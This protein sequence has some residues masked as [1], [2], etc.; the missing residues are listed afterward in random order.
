MIIFMLYHAGGA[1]VKGA[2]MRYKMLVLVLQGNGVRPYYLLPDAG[3]AQAALRI[4]AGAAAVCQY[5]G[6][7]EYLADTRLLIRHTGTV[8]QE[9]LQGAVYLRGRQP[10]AMG[11]VQRMP[12]VSDQLC[13]ARFSRCYRAACCTQDGRAISY[14]W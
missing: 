3:Y 8:Y 6:V 13:Q 14:N 1:A 2:G 10:Y 11:V 9:Q 4:S 12:H 5:T 7:E